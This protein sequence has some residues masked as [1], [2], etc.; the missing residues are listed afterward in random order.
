MEEIDDAVGQIRKAVAEAGAHGE[1]PD[2]L[3]LGQRAMDPISGY[4]DVTKSMGRPAFTLAMRSRSG[5]ERDR[6][7]REDTGYRASSAGQA[8]IAPHSI[9]ATLAGEHAGHTTDRLCSG[10][11]R[12]PDKTALSMAEIFGRT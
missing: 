1:Y 4:R 3:L 12:Y 9:V 7:G 6:P 5:T 2:Y 10:W 11:R 8:Q